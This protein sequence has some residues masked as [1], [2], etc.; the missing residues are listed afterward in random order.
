[1][2]A[3]HCDTVGVQCHNMG[4]CYTEFSQLDASDQAFAQALRIYTALLQQG[5]DWI[6]NSESISS[7]RAVVVNNY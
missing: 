7:E 1:M 5:H 6:P 2:S 3:C 4:I